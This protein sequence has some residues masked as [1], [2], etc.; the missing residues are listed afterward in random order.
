[1]ALPATGPIPPEVG[2]CF[3]GEPGKYGQ[4]L[5]STGPYMLEGA[6][7]VDA[8]SCSALKPMQGWDGVS[9]LTLVRNPDYDPRS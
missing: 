5:V 6:D 8:G 2:R 4:D 3:E 9:N 1:M 7:K